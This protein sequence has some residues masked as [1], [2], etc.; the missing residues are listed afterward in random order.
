[1]AVLDIEVLHRECRGANRDGAGEERW[2]VKL[3]TAHLHYKIP[4]IT[5]ANATSLCI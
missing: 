4:Q 2:I 1:L 5:W 3:D